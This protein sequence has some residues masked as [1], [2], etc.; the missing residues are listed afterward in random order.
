MMKF[1]KEFWERQGAVI[2]PFFKN[3]DERRAFYRKWN[4]MIRSNRR[5]RERRRA[6]ASRK[7]P[8]VYR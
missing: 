2:T 8:Q 4:E 1:D 7:R 6:R 3:A 5:K